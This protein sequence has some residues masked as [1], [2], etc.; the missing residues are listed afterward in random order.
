MHR[1]KKP[2]G[3][4]AGLSYSESGVGRPRFFAFFDIE[5]S[6]TGKETGDLLHQ[7]V[8]EKGFYPA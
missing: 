1:W 6:C 7:D 5:V 3:E 4:P 2:A 8:E